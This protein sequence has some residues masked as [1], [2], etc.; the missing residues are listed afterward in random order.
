MK[1]IHRSYKIIIFSIIISLLMHLGA[2]KWIDYHGRHRLR[3]WASDDILY[4]AYKDTMEHG[5][6]DRATPYSAY[7]LVVGDIDHGK[8]PSQALLSRFSRHKPPVL[9][10]SQA[11][12]RRG[13][14]G[15]T[16]KGSPRRLAAV[17]YVKNMTRIAPNK[18]RLISGYHIGNI[19]SHEG[20]LI[21]TRHRDGQISTQVVSSTIMDQALA[22]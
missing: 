15:L 17:L 6:S 16:L 4:F 3:Q 10:I 12:D 21:M 1:R 2:G 13:L 19:G 11:I 20:V 14:S 9:P 5:A 18:V 8:D 22:P 7:F